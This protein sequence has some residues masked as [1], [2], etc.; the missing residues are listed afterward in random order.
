MRSLLRFKLPIAANAELQDGCS[1]QITLAHHQN[2]VRPNRIFIR[3]NRIF[4]VVKDFP[5]MVDKG[6]AAE[7]WD[8][9]Q[10]VLSPHLHLN[11]GCEAPTPA[12]VLPFLV[13]N[14]GFRLSSCY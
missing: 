5:G 3:P 4:S 7:V 9:W 8:R 10:H 13:Q 6:V 2:S 14:L 11:L 12:T 1:F